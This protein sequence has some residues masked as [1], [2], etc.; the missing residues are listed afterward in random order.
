M[1][2][3][4]ITTTCWWW[5]FIWIIIKYFSA[6]INISATIQ[7]KKQIFKYRKDEGKISFIYFG[8]IQLQHMRSILPITKDTSDFSCSFYHHY[9]VTKMQ[10]FNSISYNDQLQSFFYL[11]QTGKCDSGFYDANLVFFK[12]QIQVYFLVILKLYYC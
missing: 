4:Q 8:K 10:R 7:E 3:Y 1:K 6:I 9:L 12:M 11:T 2:L 5:S